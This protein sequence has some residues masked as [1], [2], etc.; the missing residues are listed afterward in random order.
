MNKVIRKETEFAG[1]KLV[2][3]TGILAKQANM[4]IRASYGD[5]VILATATSGG[6]NPDLDFFPLGVI[7]EEKMYASGTIKSSRFV[8]RDGRPTDDAVIVRRLI[9]H[10]IRPLF[11]S[12]FRDDVQVVMSVLSLDEDANAEFLAMV[13]A[14]A[15]L[16]ASDIP[17]DG[18]MVTTTVGYKNGEYLL[19]PAKETL[20]NDS[21]L[22]MSV[23]F[24]GKEKDFLA[25]EAEVNNLADEKVLGAIE[26]AR[27]NVDSVLD[28]IFDFA[29]EVNPKGEKY[30]YESQALDANMLSEIDTYAHD[31]IVEFL[32]LDKKYTKQEAKQ[33]RDD[34]LEELF[35]KFEGTYKKSNMEKAVYAI[36]KKVVQKLV[37]EENK[38]PHGRELDSI[39][40]LKAEVGVLPRTHGTGL[41]SRGETQVLTVATL[42]NPS[43]ELIVQDMYGERTKRFLHY[44]N[45]PP[46]STGE[47]GRF[48]PANGREIGHGMLAE[49][50]LKPVIPSQEEFPYMVLLTSE[51]LSSN[52]SSS[53]ASA[54]GATLALMDAGVPIKHMVGGISIGL[55]ADRK[56]DKYVL[57]TDIQGIEDFNGHMDFKITGTDTGITA[58][59]L[60]MKLRGIPMELLPKVFERS[61]KARLS[62]LEVMKKAID[63]PRTELS[64]FA[65]K[66]LTIKVNPDQIGMIIGSGGKTIKDIQEK[67]GAELGIEDDGSIFISAENTKGAE[68][69]REIID[70]MTRE[71]KVG[72]VYDGVVEEILDFGALVEILP[73][74]VGLLHVSELDHKYV[75]NVTEYLNKGDS[76]KVKVMEVG[77]DG[78]MSLSKKALE[79]APEGDNN[80]YDAR[81]PRRFNNNNRSNRHGNRN[82]RNTRNGKHKRY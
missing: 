53:M 26:F 79:P 81:P 24:V 43:S 27:N 63:A 29:K 45:F 51:V 69:A 68:K 1:K 38:R 57:L 6:L 44:Y 10:A 7:Y 32:D 47:T 48:G 28:L 80:G 60:D 36:Q 30:V 39:R 11:P 12:D 73:G 34:L 18:P 82:N 31:K 76:V 61:K 35:A 13:A 59:Q 5:T 41:F 19:N 46:F 14:S 62:V 23:S 33:L 16:H 40:E 65:P 20:E 64:K 9:D 49:R 50:A 71:I 78:K 3:E 8:K 72:E 58:I 37:L 17:W 21:E 15:V 67:T 70:N 66:M 56:N 77:R 22:N 52:G 42:A 54:C 4:S 2:F 74:R 75:E 55:V 25:I